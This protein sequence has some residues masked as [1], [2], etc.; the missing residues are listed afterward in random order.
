V[1]EPPGWTVQAHWSVGGDQRSYSPVRASTR[2]AARRLADEM[3]ETLS[4]FV[5]LEIRIEPEGDRSW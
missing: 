4:H 5:G 1:S 2:A 3:A